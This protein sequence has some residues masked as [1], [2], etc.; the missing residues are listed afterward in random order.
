MIT[1]IHIRDLITLMIAHNFVEKTRNCFM[2]EQFIKSSACI[3]IQ[4]MYISQ[5]RG[6]FSMVNFYEI[7]NILITK[8]NF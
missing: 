1:Y 3:K 7:M 8:F 2:L 6:P 4:L 5:Y